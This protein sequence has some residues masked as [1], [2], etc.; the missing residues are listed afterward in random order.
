M[1]EQER[2]VFGALIVVLVTTIVTVI[3]WI[4]V[5]GSN[6]KSSAG[7]LMAC[8]DTLITIGMWIMIY[9]RLVKS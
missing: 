3:R 7:Y 1:N 6:E 4:R 5:F 8:W 2:F 9:N